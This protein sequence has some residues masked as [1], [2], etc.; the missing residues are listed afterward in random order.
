MAAPSRALPVPTPETKHFCA[1][2]CQIRVIAFVDS[3]SIPDPVRWRGAEKRKTHS[4]TSR[5]RTSRSEQ[6]GESA[7]KTWHAKR[8]IMRME[9]Q[10]KVMLADVVM[11]AEGR[12]TKGKNTAMESYA[13]SGCSRLRVS[14]TTEYC[15]RCSD[16]S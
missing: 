14:G 12:E 15:L 8:R 13:C 11:F 7:A 2:I 3:D 5:P 6:R 16:R 4:R 10:Q 1:S 9:C